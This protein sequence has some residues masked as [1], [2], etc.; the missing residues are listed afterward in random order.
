MRLTDVLEK[1]PIGAKVFHRQMGPG[2]SGTVTHKTEKSYVL[3]LSNGFALV[4]QIESVDAG[5]SLTLEKK[6]VEL[7]C[8][9]ERGGYSGQN[10]RIIFYPKGALPWEEKNTP[11][12]MDIKNFFRHEA[13]DTEIETY[14]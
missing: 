14:E 12:Q 3:E 13:G 5:W 6:K 8:W 10:Y 1:A 11:L 2:V 4:E 7:A 9:I